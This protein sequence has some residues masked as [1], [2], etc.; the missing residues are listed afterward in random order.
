M[1][2]G[3]KPL[4]TKWEREMIRSPIGWLND[5]IIS[6]AQELILQQF[7]TMSDLQPTTF[8]Q[9]MAFQVHRGE[10][11]HVEGCHWCTVST[12]GCDDGVI[13]RV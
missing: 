9:I 7:P 12:V 13:Q 11:L 2:C 8:A 10:I 5:S 1:V 6:A 3:S 4:C